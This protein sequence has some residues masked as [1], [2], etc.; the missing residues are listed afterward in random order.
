MDLGFIE[1][2]LYMEKLLMVVISPNY[3]S[4]SGEKI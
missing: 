4:A 2:P 3:K 1:K